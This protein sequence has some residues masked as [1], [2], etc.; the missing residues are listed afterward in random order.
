M[1]GLYLGTTTVANLYLG[2]TEVCS[3]YLGTNQPFDNCTYTPSTLTLLYQSSY[4]GD[5]AYLITDNPANGTVLSGQPGTTGTF[6]ISNPSYSSGF[7][8]YPGATDFPTL[9]STSDISATFPTSGNLNVTGP[10]K[11]GGLN[12]I[13]TAPNITASL[14]ATATGSNYSVTVSGSPDTGP[15]PLSYSFTITVTPNTNYAINSAPTDTLGSTYVSSGSNWV[16]T[17]SGTTSSN[18]SLTPSVTATAALQTFTYSAS[19]TNNITGSGSPTVTASL[20]GQ[21]SVVVPQTA[22]P[23][24]THSFGSLSGTRG[25]TYT[26][27]ASASVQSGYQFTSGPTYTP[28]SSIS[29]TYSPSPQSKNITVTGTT[30]IIQNDA[31]FVGDG[32]A[33]PF[34]SKSAAC[35]GS[36]GNSRTVYYVGGSAGDPGLNTLL[37]LN[38][39]LSSGQLSTGWYYNDDTGEPVYYTYNSGI[40]SI[41]SC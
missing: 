10:T 41:D 17:V 6:V 37:Y 22:P 30:A 14:S 18:L 29:I 27:G 15:A 38:A 40:S 36:S 2:T 3:T 33:V 20:T 5:R 23:D 32:G 24:N 4:G 28:S 34:T 21:S 31:Q 39:N 12:T 8:G 19:V 13:P 35:S 26:L 11:S 1:A 16:A 7:Q 9:S 25:T